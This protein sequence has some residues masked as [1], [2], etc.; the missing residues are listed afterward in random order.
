MELKKYALGD[1]CTIVPGFAF[2]SNDFG[3]GENIAVKIKDI[4]PPSVNIK[5]AERVCVTPQDKF[6]LSE[7]DYIMA[8]TGATIGKVGKLQIDA[9]NVYINQ[10]VCKFNPITSVCDKEYLYYVLSTSSFRNFIYNN[11]DSKLAQPNIGH[12]TIYKYTHLFPSNIKEQKLIASVLNNIDRKIELNKQINDNLEAMAKQLYDYWFVQ[13]DFPNE[14]G[15]PYK[16][17]GGAMVWNEKLKREIPQGWTGAKIK[18]VAQIYSGGTP[19]ST[20]S[21]YYDGGDIPWINSGELNNPIITSTTNYITEEGLNNSSA[22]LYPQD[23]V[24]VALYGATAGKVSLLSF[25]ACSNQAVCGVIPQ[26]KIMTTYIRYYLSSLYEHFITLSSGSARDNI[27]QDTIKNTIL[28]IPQGKILKEFSDAV[29]LIISKIIANQK[30][31]ENLTKQRDELL[32]L[33]MNGQATVNYHLAASFLSSFILYRDQYKLYDMKE[34]VIQAILDGMRAVLTDSQLE[35]LTDVTRRALSECEITPKLADEEQRNKENAELLGAF[36]SSKKVEGCSEKTIHYYKSSI[37]KLIATVKKNVCDIATNDIRCYLAEQ[38]EQR[39]LSKVTIDNLRRIYS[40][41][42]SWLEDED[43]ITKSPVRRIHKVR[44]DAL[45][46]E[47]LTDENIEVLRD[48]CQELRDIAM[49]DLLLSTGMRVGELVKINRED[50]DFQER[51]CVV[52][53]KGNKER[54]VYFNARTKIHLKKYLEQR[55]DS[56]PALFVSLHEPHTRLTISGVEV[57]L[58]QLGKRVN[59]NKVHPHKFR[60]TLATMAIDKGMPIEQV[61]KMLGHVKIDTTLHYA[62]VNQANVKIAHRKFLN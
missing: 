7:G 59:L 44:T 26:N 61:Q 4:E 62:M 34:T 27:S 43:Y 56:N 50:I 40:S 20:N 45:V 8:M 47:V 58:R 6:R 1:V 54:E 11:V 31:M 12:T 25:E 52:F 51:Q 55:T 19:T 30:E 2:K 41:F 60:R 39:G 24:L 10:R 49:I 21:E 48:S 3:S 22:K 53:G 18:D 46:K 16:S 36:I 28:P 17:N 33:L 32:P 23:T 13:F 9:K 5:N 38:Q 29:A 37:E 35:L 15:K 42:F 14:E 57:R